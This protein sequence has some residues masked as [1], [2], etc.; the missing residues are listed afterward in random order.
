VGSHFWSLSIA[1]RSAE[2]SQVADAVM[3]RDKAVARS[4]I[5]STPM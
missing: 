4:L 3:N 2:R 1:G 5:N